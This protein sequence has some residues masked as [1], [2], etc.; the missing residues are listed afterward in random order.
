MCCQAAVDCHS[1]S[2]ARC[3]LHLAS[4]RAS[5][6]VPHPRPRPR[7]RV[8]VTRAR[9]SCRASLP[10][11]WWAAAPLRST[12]PPRCEPAGAFDTLPPPAPLHGTR[13]SST[14]IMNGMQRFLSRREKHQAEKRKSKEAARNKVRSISAVLILRALEADPTLL[15]HHDNRQSLASQ[16]PPACTRYSPTKN[17]SQLP[18]RMP[19]RT[20]VLE[21]RSHFASIADPHRSQCCFHGC[22]VPALQH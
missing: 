16:Y 19:R 8:S 4:S 15:T 7:G 12:T 20:C 10:I 3:L 5:P 13:A 14:P 2:R 22:R 1:A 17:K 21:A 6:C 11:V 18:T 9:S